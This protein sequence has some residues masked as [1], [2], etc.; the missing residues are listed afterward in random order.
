MRERKVSRLFSILSYKWFILSSSQGHL[1]KHTSKNPPRNVY[2]KVRQQT[3]VF[4]KSAGFYQKSNDFL[5][6]GKG[7][8]K[9]SWRA[10][11]WN[12]EIS[13]SQCCQE[14]SSLASSCTPAVSE[15]KGLCQKTAERQ[16]DPCPDSSASNTKVFS[17]STDDTNKEHSLDCGSVNALTSPVSLFSL[18]S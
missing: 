18:C 13:K 16:P 10:Q 11:M 3:L 6:K 5:P 9:A 4:V 2:A 1:C 12:A 15:Q 14:I 7:L 17:G 8:D